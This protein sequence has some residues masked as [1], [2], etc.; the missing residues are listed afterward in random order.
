MASNRRDN[1]PIEALEEAVG[2]SVDYIPITDLP[3]ALSSSDGVLAAEK[4]R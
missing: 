1:A 2:E 4:A 3:E